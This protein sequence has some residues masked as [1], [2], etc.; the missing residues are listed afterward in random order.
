MKSDI[1]TTQDAPPCACPEP[2]T[3]QLRRS[4]SETRQCPAMTP[5][6]QALPPAAEAVGSSRRPPSA[7]TSKWAWTAGAIRRL[8][9]GLPKGR[10]P[11]G[12]TLFRQG[13]PGDSIFYIGSGR[14]HRTV[15]T[16]K[17]YERLVAIL[18]PGDFCGE[19]CL[20]RT[21]CH[22][23]SAVV[24]EDA[25]IA[26]IDRA[27]MSRLYDRS[28]LAH[29]FSTFLLTHTLETEAALIDQLVGSA[30]QRLRRTL[31][32]LARI[33]SLGAD[34]GTISNVKQETLA[35]LVGT[36]RPRINY[37]LNKFRKRGWIDYGRQVGLG[38][39]QVHPKLKQAEEEE[40]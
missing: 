23:T 3:Y 35:S 25:E 22:S 11:T 40:S 38:A 32:R 29:A 39:I 2:L 4:Y 37:F 33:E 6:R 1:P 14:I 21:P 5:A 36:T 31:L 34:S 15:T 24:V 27:L 17:G 12:H 28:D 9:V 19:E 7:A 8:C 16:K 18:G 30:E 26:R 10:Y 13:E 20:G